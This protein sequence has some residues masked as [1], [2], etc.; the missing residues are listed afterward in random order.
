MKKLIY[1][2]I[3]MALVVSIISCQKFDWFDHHNNDHGHLKQA[4]DYSSDVVLKWMDM[5]LR[6]IRTNATPLGGLQP[7]RFFAY[8]GIALYQSVV[9]G[10]PAYQTLSGQVSDLPSSPSTQPGLSYHWAAVANSALAAMN[11]NFFPAT[12]DIN[13]ASMDSLENALNAVYESE[14]T[15]AEF[16][17]SIDYGKAVA[18]LVFD[19]CKTDGSSHASDPYTAPT[20]PGLWIP[21][22]PALAPAIA[23][24]WGNNRLLVN[25]SL[26]GSVPVP[27]P[28]Y[29][30]DPSSDFYKMAEEVYD[31]SQA[32]TP[33]QTAIG[34]YYRDNPGYGGGHYLSILMQILK[35][36]NSH[37][38]FASLAY[39]KTGIG[40]VEAAIGCWRVKYQ[41][42]IERPITYI[43]D[44]NLLNHPNWVPLFGTPAFPEYTSG[45]STVGGCFTTLM[46]SLFGE[47]YH[48][49]NHTYD[50]LG[51]SPRSFNSFRDLANEI[52]ASRVFA[53]IHYRISCER[54]Q[55]AGEKIG[56]NIEAKLK[57]KK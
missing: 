17:R 19:W 44:V 51:M 23:P 57:F 10:M 52:S 30:T 13:K 6:L 55:Q 1:L 9:P 18:Q 35:K 27:P 42:N 21:T 50:Y 41:Y 33:E 28:A 36:E 5:Q 22:P 8:C 39:A 43:T 29:S 2:S 24:F 20:G 38:D 54:G 48:F 49:T 56:K 12:S 25:G 45:H 3:A 4:K 53:G 14:V 26:D 11:R 31:V 32:L 37:L 15:A 34:L 40:C 16:Q 47:H 7:G 46:T